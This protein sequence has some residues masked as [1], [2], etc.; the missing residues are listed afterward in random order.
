MASKGLLAAAQGT[1]DAGTRLNIVCYTSLQWHDGGGIYCCYDYLPMEVTVV[2][3]SWYV[4][5]GDQTERRTTDFPAFRFDFGFART[6]ASE[7][8]LR[9]G[10]KRAALEWHRDRHVDKGPAQRARR[11]RPSSR[12]SA[13]RSAC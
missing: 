2:G 13:R 6:Q 12:R 4:V 1:S 5:A 10:Y 9:S 7:R 8:E 3:A 11:P